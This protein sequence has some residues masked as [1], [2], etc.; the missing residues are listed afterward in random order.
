M[1]VSSAAAVTLAHD[2]MN[3]LVK[4][5]RPSLVPVSA[6]NPSDN[7]NSGSPV[8]V[9]TVGSAT[10]M[11]G[12]AT[13]ERRNTRT[14]P[15]PDTAAAHHTSANMTPNAGHLPGGSDAMAKMKPSVTISLT[16]ASAL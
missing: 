13:S 8:L 12:I 9:N 15:T 5:S 1:D 14:S 4:N 7:S 10:R 3:T 11:N 6:N 16:R 2:L